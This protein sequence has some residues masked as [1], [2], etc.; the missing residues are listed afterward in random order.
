MELESKIILKLF[1]H[2][3]KID[4]VHSHRGDTTLI[5][6]CN[7]FLLLALIA[8]MTSLNQFILHIAQLRAGS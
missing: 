3:I 2:N 6:L 5:S 7:N 4:R 1:L 8:R